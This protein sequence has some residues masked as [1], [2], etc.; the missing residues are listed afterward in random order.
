[1]P[2]YVPRHII[3]NNPVGHATETF[4]A[5]IPRLDLDI[6]PGVSSPHLHDLRHA[7]AVGVLTRWYRL[8]LDPQAHLTSDS[9]LYEYPRF[10]KTP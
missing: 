8:G 4:H 6:A 7:F 9:A 3:D 1:V 2:Y 5:L 10:C